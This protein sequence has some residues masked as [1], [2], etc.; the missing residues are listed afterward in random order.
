LRRW[1]EEE[2]AEDHGMEQIQAVTRLA[3]QDQQLGLEERSPAWSQG[4]PADDGR[5][6]RR[7]QSGMQDR[8]GDMIAEGR[9][10]QRSGGAAEHQRRRQFRIVSPAQEPVATCQTHHEFRQAHERVELERVEPGKKILVGTGYDMVR[11]KHDVGQGRGNGHHPAPEA[12]RR[13]AAVRD[14][15]E[16]CQQYR[17]EYVEE[18]LNRNRPV[19]PIPSQRCLRHPGL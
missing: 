3:E 8:I 16:T 5:K 15:G 17:E 1:W 2:H 14:P 11:R 9:R 12:D 13:Q 4:Q 7:E 19:H 10:E 18:D 6:G